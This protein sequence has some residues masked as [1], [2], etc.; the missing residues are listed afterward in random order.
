MDQSEGI[1]RILQSGGRIAALLTLY[2]NR[3]SLRS[4]IRAIRGLQDT[5][6]NLATSDRSHRR[7]SLIPRLRYT[8]GSVLGTEDP[9]LSF[10]PR[11]TRAEETREGEVAA[12]REGSR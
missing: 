4:A 3:Q 10:L 9:T 2:R 5:P 6:H 12:R 7:L 8:R 11:F 1:D